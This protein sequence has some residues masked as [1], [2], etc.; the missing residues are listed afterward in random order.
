MTPKTLCIFGLAAAGGVYVASSS[1]RSWIDPAAGKSVQAQA[2]PSGRPAESSLHE[3]SGSPS[4]EGQ[5]TSVPQARTSATGTTEDGKRPRNLRKV[6][7]LLAAQSPPDVLLGVVMNCVADILESEG[8]RAQLP[9]GPGIR[10]QDLDTPGRHAILRQGPEG[11]FLLYAERKRFPLLAALSSSI[12]AGEPVSEEQWLA[13]LDLA[14][15][16]ELA[17][18]R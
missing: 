11:A 17:A 8:A 1:T 10:L 16:A 3:P 13:A 2:D 4:F 7:E 12:E 14:S 18:G 6:E 5:R 15:A 9:G